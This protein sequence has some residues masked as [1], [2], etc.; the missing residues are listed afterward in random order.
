[1]IEKH[2]IDTGFLKR[3]E[4]QPSLFALAVGDGARAA[5]CPRCGEPALIHQEGCAICQ[6]CAYSKCG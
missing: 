1:V 5:Q 4:P 3:S 6:A 2:M